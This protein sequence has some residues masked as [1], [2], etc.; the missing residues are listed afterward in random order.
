[1]NFLSVSLKTWRTMGGFEKTIQ[2]FKNL[3]APL[4]AIFH[5]IGAALQ[6][7]FPSGNK[8]VGKTLYAMSAGF[9]AI[10]RPLQWFADVIEGT[11]PIV[12]TF[13]KLLHIIGAAI[14][15]AGGTVADFIKNLLDM[16]HIDAPSSSGLVGFVKDLAH[17]ISDA[18]N[19]VDELISKGAS[20][21]SA[22]GAIDFKMP[23]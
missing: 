21:G 13:F 2:G 19:K 1:F 22:F 16:V 14:K 6:A 15:G 17:A 11:T 9:E 4:G 20:I 5:V 8:G 18:I 23:S 10:T 3:L 12:A 7:A